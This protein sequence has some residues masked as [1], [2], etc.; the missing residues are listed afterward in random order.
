MRW[1]IA[2]WRHNPTNYY[3]VFG[4]VVR[5]EAGQII[6]M[7]SEYWHMNSDLQ[8]LNGGPYISRTMSTT[9]LTFP[10]QHYSWEAM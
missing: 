7:S 2:I 4:D 3:A 1:Y 8:D 5:T 6:L 10:E 9:A